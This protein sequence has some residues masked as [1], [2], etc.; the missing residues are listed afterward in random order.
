MDLRGLRL[1]RLVPAIEKQK[2]AALGRMN[3]RVEL[4]GR[5]ATPAELMG[6]ADG[7]LL[8]AA[9][10]GTASALLVEILGLD[11]AE[12]VTLLGK[13]R[14]DPLRCAVMDLAVKGGT[15]KTSTFVIDASDTVL[16]VEG[17]ADLGKE[18][19]ALTAR[20]EPRDASPFTLRTPVDISGTFLDPVVRPKPGPLATRAVAAAALAAIN[21]LLALIPFVDPGGD[22]EGG[23]QPQKK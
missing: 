13:K 12:A 22:P 21:P 17:S 8:F 11:A 6:S 16:S 15:A 9:E 5:G 2:A 14:E 3:G 19:L 10:R 18:R 7:R 1:S 4:A 20:A 23:C